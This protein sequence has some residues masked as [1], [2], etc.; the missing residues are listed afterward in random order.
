MLRGV[1]S[2]GQR[3]AKWRDAGVV[4][5]RWTRLRRLDADAKL[6]LCDVCCG[7]ARGP[8]LLETTVSPATPPRLSY[9]DTR[10]RVPELLGVTSNAQGPRL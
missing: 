1:N 2:L 10:V 3:Q 9:W 5:R 4:L 6:M 7:G 8:R